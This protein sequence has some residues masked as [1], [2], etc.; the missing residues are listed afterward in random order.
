MLTQYSKIVLVALLLFCSQVA[1]AT[2]WSPSSGALKAD[3]GHYIATTYKDSPTEA[4]VLC[5]KP[6]VSGVS[7]RQTWRN[8]EPAREKYDFRAFD[9]TLSAIANSSNPSCKLWVFVEYKSFANSPPS[10]PNVRNPCP[11]WLEDSKGKP[12]YV[13]NDNT[14][15]TGPI[16]GATNTSPIVITTGSTHELHTGQTVAIQGLVGNAAG[17]GTWT[18]TVRD[19]THF[20]L[21]SSRG[22]GAYVAGGAWHLNPVY[23]CKMYDPTVVA[24]YNKLQRALADR[25]DF[26]PN[27]EGIIF[28]ESAL[29]FSDGY[30]PADY[31][32]EGLRDGLSNLVKGCA[33][34]FKASRC[35][36]FLNFLNGNQS[37][38]YNVSDTISAI[39]NNQACYSGPDILF[40]NE[41]L[42]S[43]INRTYEVLTRHGGCRSNSAQ[44]DSFEEKGCAS[45]NCTMA[46]IFNFAVGGTFGDFDERAPYRSGL[47][48]NSYLFWNNRETRSATGLDISDALSVIASKPYGKGWYGQC[49]G[50]GGPPQAFKQ[51]D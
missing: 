9:D 23:T 10:S 28:Q 7:Y 13:P 19:S 47:C 22:N 12:G 8:V 46:D 20:S 45:G 18:I 37:Y 21:D 29:G 16:F 41:T 36:A 44:N 34:A 25:Y 30:E 51:V 3:Y 42:Y 17:N 38:L 27:V 31:S 6:G 49:S 40:S 11:A 43:N 50:G 1:R 5:G 24:E 15:A 39:P 48:V 32:P 14:D 4:A 35:L 2:L 26:D 33:A